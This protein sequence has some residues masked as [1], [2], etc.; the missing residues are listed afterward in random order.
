MD[1]ILLVNEMYVQPKENRNV[2]PNVC[3]VLSISQRLRQIEGND[4]TFQHHV[5]GFVINL[6]PC[7][8]R[9]VK[10]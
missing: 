6:F 5:V 1:S 7:P 10:V 2:L 8:Q 9:E 4:E 3:S